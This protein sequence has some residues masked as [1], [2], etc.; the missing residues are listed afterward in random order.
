MLLRIASEKALGLGLGSWATGQLL[1]EAHNLLHAD[2]IGRGA[3]SLTKCQSCFWT[4][5]I[6]KF[7]AIPGMRWALRSSYTVRGCVC[8]ECELED[9]R[10]QLGSLQK[11][12]F[13]GFQGESYV[14]RSNLR[15]IV[16][17]PHRTRG[18]QEGVPWGG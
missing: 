10:K 16:S 6:G 7:R 3:N 13:L 2:G 11:D 1:V 8:G 17:I 12:V 15:A 14:G 5:L 18:A 9:A 4:A